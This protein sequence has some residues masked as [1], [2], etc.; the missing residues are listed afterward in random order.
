MI[1]KYSLTE[2]INAKKYRKIIDQVFEKLPN[3]D[4][5]H[6]V[7]FIKKMNFTTWKNSLTKI[8]G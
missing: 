3:I 1:P 8:P 6:D 2:G 7:N 5:W 4:E